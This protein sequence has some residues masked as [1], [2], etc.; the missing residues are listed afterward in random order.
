MKKL[1][2]L[3]YQCGLW[4]DGTPDSWDQEALNKYGQQIVDECIAAIERASRTAGATT[5]D[6]DMSLAVA[7]KSIAE[8]QKIF[9]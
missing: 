2:E 5:Y 7:A 9:K 8:I 4:A 3:A 1:D 6:R